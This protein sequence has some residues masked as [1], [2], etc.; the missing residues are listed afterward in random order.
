MLGNVFVHCTEP[1]YARK[2]NFVS[3]LDRVIL[4]CM[5]MGYHLNHIIIEKNLNHI[6]FPMVP[7]LATINLPILNS[8]ASIHPSFFINYVLQTLRTYLEEET[9]ARNGRSVNKKKYFIYP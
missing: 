9:I 1:S 5:S 6:P 7:R 4:T 2:L 3:L 8:F